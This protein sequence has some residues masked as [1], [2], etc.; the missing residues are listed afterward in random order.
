VESSA[1]SYGGDANSES[2]N[3]NQN[4]ISYQEMTAV[5]YGST[6][7]ATSYYGNASVTTGDASI[8]GGSNN[9]GVTSLSSNT[10][11]GSV[12]Q[13]GVSLSALGTVNV[14]H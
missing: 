10:G 6:N 12:V 3:T 1:S 2:F 13:Q 5:S 4:A 14:G 7:T 8:A 11:S 9:A